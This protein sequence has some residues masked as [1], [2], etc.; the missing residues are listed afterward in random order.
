MYNHK[1]GVPGAS[2]HPAR[3]QRR[4]GYR[5]ATAGTAFIQITLRA[6]IRFCPE[7][8]VRPRSG[9]RNRDVPKGVLLSR[10]A[11]ERSE[12]RASGLSNK[13]LSAA[14][15]MRCGEP[16]AQY[17]IPGAS[18]FAL[19]DGELAAVISAFATYSVVNMPCAAVGADGQSGYHS[20]VV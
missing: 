2:E 10:Q 11:G 5:Y 18:G 6:S 9:G 16:R 13:A 20:V 19:L 8:A 3:N 14:E 12:S 15:M 4:P 17:F 7:R 1:R